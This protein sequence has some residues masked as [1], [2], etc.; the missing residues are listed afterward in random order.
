LTKQYELAKVQEAKEIPTVKV[1]DSPEVPERKSYPPRLLI[2]FLGT[3]F[4]FALGIFWVAGKS[5]WEEVEP[6]DPAKVL[7]KDVA[8]G[9]K[10]R[11]PFASTNGNRTKESADSNVDRNSSSDVR[12]T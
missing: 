3:A 4:A 7:V 5:R 10:M 8:H 12:G 1:L 11:L 6:Q 2:V 9:L